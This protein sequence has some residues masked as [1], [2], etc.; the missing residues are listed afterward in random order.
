[1]ARVAH[2]LLAA[3]IVTSVASCT[4]YSIVQPQRTAIKN[5]FTVEP[6]QAWN[7]INV[8][9]GV[10]GSH[11]MEAWTADGDQLDMMLFFAGVADGQTLMPP[12]RDEDKA[13]KLP[14]FR[15]GM[16]ANEVKDVLEATLGQFMSSALV[17]TRNLRPAKFGGQDGYRFDFNLVGKDEVDRQGIAAGAVV[18]GKLYSVVFMGTRLYHYGLRLQDAE[19][20][21]SSIQFIKS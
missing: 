17:E 10:G 19:H 21:V 9:F 20:I 7:K 1:M 16:S 6:G 3:L 14:V 13:K 11:P 8:Q 4:R 2:L 15:S 12:P 5:G 18:N